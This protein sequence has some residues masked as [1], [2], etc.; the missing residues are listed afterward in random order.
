LENKPSDKEANP[1]SITSEPDREE[2]I[3]MQIVVDAYNEEERAMG[4]YCHLE[5]EMNFPFTARCREKRS[6]SPLR[7]N[8]K[9]TV[10]GMADSDE[11]RSEM[12]V[13]IEWDEQEL[14][15]P[16]SQLEVIKADDTTRQAVAD[17]HYWVGRGY[18]F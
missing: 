4:W 15:I 12:F 8:C 2:R 10:I 17:W 14:A 9:V 6:I 5:N 16:L 7:S 11:C 1:L 18:Q 13:E 3:V